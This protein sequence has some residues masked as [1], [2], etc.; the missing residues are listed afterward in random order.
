MIWRQ[1]NK[2]YFGVSFL[3]EYAVL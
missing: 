2:R 3:T 1:R